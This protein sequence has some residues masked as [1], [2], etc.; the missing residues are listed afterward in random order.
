MQQF[1][2]YSRSSHSVQE[3]QTQSGTRKR[4]FTPRSAKNREQLL[5]AM[6]QNTAMPLLLRSKKTFKHGLGESTVRLFKK[7]YLEELKRAKEKTS[8]RS[9]RSEKDCCQGSWQASFA[10]RV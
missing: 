10:W 4:N 1:N 9:F 5:T 3:A 6:L 8:R 2:E 7:K